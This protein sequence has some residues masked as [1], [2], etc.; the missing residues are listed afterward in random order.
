MMRKSFVKFLIFLLITILLAGCNL[1]SDVY[2]VTVR[3]DKTLGEVIG[4]GE[5]ERGEKVVL[6]ATPKDG[7]YIDSWNNVPQETNFSENKVSFVINSNVEVE[8]N[9]SKGIDWK[10][11][12]SKD[13]KEGFVLPIIA[14]EK[15]SYI[16]IN[17]SEVIKPIEYVICSFNYSNVGDNYNENAFYGQSLEVNNISGNL[18]LLLHNSTSKMVEEI[19]HIKKLNN[20]SPLVVINDTEVKNYD[21]EYRQIAN[22]N[23][24]KIVQLSK[25][26]LIVL[27]DDKYGFIDYSGEVVVDLIYDEV[28]EL[29]EQ[30]D[31]ILI[32]SRE[33]TSGVTDSKTGK[34]LIDFKFDNI[35]WFIEHGGIL[36][37]SKGEIDYLYNSKGEL[38]FDISGYDLK[39]RSKSLVTYFK[40]SKYGVIDYINGK[41]IFDSVYD[42]IKLLDED[43]L[44][45]KS[46]GKWGLLDNSGE[47]L[48]EL[49]FDKIDSFKN[50]RAYFEKN[51]LKGY[52][53]KSG[54]IE[55]S[56]DF[57]SLTIYDEEVT[58]KYITFS[59]NGKIGIII[60]DEIVIEATLD[61]YAPILG[62]GD[63]IYL[64]IDKNFP[65]FEKGGSW[66]V[67]SVEEK[68][69][70]TDFEFSGNSLAY[71][72][73]FTGIPSMIRTKIGDQ[74]ESLINLDTKQT[75]IRP[76]EYDDFFYII[77]GMVRV[78]QDDK[79]GFIDQVGVLKA[80]LKFDYATNFSNGI[81][82]V[83]V[84][85]KIGYINKNGE[86][87]IDLVDWSI[88]SS[89]WNK[90]VNLFYYEAIGIYKGSGNLYFKKDGEVLHPIK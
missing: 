33:Q 87:V 13:A 23:F 60:D 68:D 30:F 59:K 81:A 61:S 57:D 41:V 40:D 71:V 63:L 2:E 24:D 17:G 74:G 38:L 65:I 46:K 66:G 3:Y 16:D 42:D 89:D 4:S 9:F 5:Y 12:I 35:E 29:N 32:M 70:V 21:D 64:Y 47:L 53:N 69:F 77:D 67:F 73:N 43:L 1:K 27:K 85:D 31:N 14:G 80:E 56:G 54:E 7:F 62:S 78:R 72:F 22:S 52:L 58:K 48:T 37:A 20:N 11:V 49:H 82:G 55:F 51:G 50:E 6:E 19:L 44:A 15:V 88:N 36:K 28:L 90:G 75:I 84:G 76:G 34:E 45:V 18:P 8:V 79:F 26:G 86:Y 10:S 83:R 39:E 25:N